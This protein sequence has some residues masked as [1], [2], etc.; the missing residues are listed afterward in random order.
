MER[1]LRLGG[2]WHTPSIAAVALAL[3]AVTLVLPAAARAS[4]ACG[5]TITTSVALDQDLVCAGPG[6]FVTGS[7]LFDL[8]VDLNGHS[9][10][11]T[12]GSAG[13]RVIGAN[14]NVKNGAIRGFDIGISRDGFRALAGGVFEN[15]GI[16]GNR[17]A[18]MSF[19][20][21][22]GDVIRHTFV[23]E[24]G[25]GISIFQGGVRVL[26]NEVVRNTGD[27][28]F[29]QEG[30][31]AFERNRI[32]GNGGY[33]IFTHIHGVTI[34]DN[35]VH[36]NGKTG[37]FVG[38]NPYGPEK[39]YIARNVASGNGGNGIVFFD[40]ALALGPYDGGGNRAS[41]NAI[42][43]QCVNIVCEEPAEEE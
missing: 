23:A 20:L 17:F 37:I 16:T 9:I 30:G 15:L 29:N 3:T 6:L 1:V 8:T 43:P 4:V 34:T 10:T 11:G 35:S 40:P 21:S 25:I 33:G 32:V 39:Y 2:S 5:D 18:G 19:N 7:P 27:G 31:S 42:E 13:L 36:T 38:F 12:A 24:N 22:P 41:R 28:I 14:V 26:E